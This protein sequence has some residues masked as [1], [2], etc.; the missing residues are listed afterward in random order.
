MT[1]KYRPHQIESKWQERWETEKAF[2]TIEDPARRKYYLLEMFPYPSGRIHMGHVRNYTIGDV[3]ARYKR[4]KGW[5]V[6]H[7]MG[8][9][10]FGMPAEN[11]AIAHKVH[12]ARWTYDNIQ[13]MRTQLKRLGFSYDWDRELATCDPSYYKWEQ[14]FFL[15]M[16]ERGLVYRRLSL[17]NW[18]GHC[19][20]VLANE[21]VVGDGRCW[22]CDQ[23]VQGKELEQW[24]FRITEYAEELLE[25]CGKLPGWPDKVLVMQ[26][27]WIGKSLG[28]EIDFPLED[29]TGKLTV[30]TTRPDTLYG[31][32]FMSL[33]VEH[34]LALSLCRNTPQEQEVRSFVE[35]I[36]GMNRRPGAE[37]DLEKEGVFTGRYCLNPLTGQR[38]PIFVANFVLMEYGT[39]AVMAVPT[40]DQRDFEFARKY[41]LPQRVVI[42]P[43]E[44]PILS[45]ETM[46]E[47]YEGPGRLV[48]SGSFNGLDN[49]TAKKAIT[50]HLEEMGRGREKVQYR[51]RD[52]GVSRQRYWGAPIPMLYCQRCGIVPVP[53]KDLPVLLPLEAE[54]APSGGSP[55]PLLKEFV[56]T[57]CP[58][59]Q[60][61]ARR[62]TDTMDTFV[63]SS[64][65]FL[66]FACPDFDQ[67]PLDRARVDYWMPVDQ[68]IGGIEHAVLHLLYSRFFTKVLRDLGWLQVDEPF[69]RLLTQGMVIKDGAKMSKSKGNVVDPDQ[70]VEKYGADTVRLFCLFAS[71]PERDLEW[72]DQGVEGSYRFLHRLWNLVLGVK[73]KIADRPWGPNSVPADGAHRRLYVKLNQTI[74]KVTE[75]IEDR[76]HFNTA[77]SAVME[78]INDLGQYLEEAPED[79]QKDQQVARVVDTALV[80]LSPIV[81]H[82]TQELWERLGRPGEIQRQPWPEWDPQ[83]LTTE[84]Q[85]VVIQ[86][87][88]KVRARMTVTAAVG[89]EE[90]K[91]RALQLP[92]IR[93]WLGHREPKKVILVQRK[94]VNIVV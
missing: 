19:Q 52:W 46:E 12:P 27:N 60:G 44:G 37:A 82:I 49:E 90:I 85:V 58:R 22:R 43:M 53:E 92:R 7:P 69:T 48:N 91:Q 8:W 63:E 21:Q 20:T 70:L 33:A 6:L 25:G 17:V 29:G 42:Q 50:R 65:Y 30:F 3:V 59:C 83:A 73:S 66:R 84:E 74:K 88:G 61:P 51:L 89:E 77:I 15:K 1:E 71:P 76:F 32:T 13:Y 14:L 23:P 10:A 2:R 67:A 72:S 11:A 26:R 87:N 57:T 31:A 39:G 78:L 56:E 40:H 18:C 47:A 79:P 86:V 54:I 64:W 45:P 38:M 75:D 55:L 4:M 81:P 94:L 5:N 68:Y 9:D 16:W 36:R 35:R 24:F 80:L 62:E 41:G 28:T 34:P 93:E